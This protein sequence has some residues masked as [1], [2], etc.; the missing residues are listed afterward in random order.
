MN[1]YWVTTSDHD[2][3]W[4]IVADTAEEAASFHEDMEGYNPGD[5]TAEMIIEIPDGFPVETDWPSDDVLKACG[6]LIVVDGSTRVVKI[7]DRTFCEGLLESEIR[8]VDDK[9]R[10]ALGEDPLKESHKT[11][12]H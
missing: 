7:G 12:E 3:D 10:E 6:A 4:F 1:L 2:E 8:R 9:I 5:A 11:T